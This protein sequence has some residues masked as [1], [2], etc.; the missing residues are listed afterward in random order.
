MITKGTME[1][2]AQG[3]FDEYYFDLANKM[4]KALKKAF[5]VERISDERTGRI[6]KHFC[7]NMRGQV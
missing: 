1:I 6:I 5:D 3:L 7:E 4:N 2:V